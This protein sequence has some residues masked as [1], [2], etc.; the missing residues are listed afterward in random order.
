MRSS[1]SFRHT[2]LVTISREE[3]KATLP[4]FLFLPIMSSSGCQTGNGFKL[5]V[6]IF[7]LT[8]MR[9]HHAYFPWVFSSIVFLTYLGKLEA[10]LLAWYV[11]G[12]WAK[13]LIDIVE[14]SLKM[15]LMPCGYGCISLHSISMAGSAGV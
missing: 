15:L 13:I 1:K 3:K 9:I 5:D 8:R 7:T 6:S 4:F 10:T 12:K 11:T 2:P 14:K